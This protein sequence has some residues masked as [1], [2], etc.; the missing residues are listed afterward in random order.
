MSFS[1]GEFLQIETIDGKTISITKYHLIARRNRSSTS[2]DE[3][4]EFIFAK[5]LRINDSVRIIDQNH[6][7][8]SRIRSIE[9]VYKRGWIAPLTFEG[10]LFVND[11]F[12]SCFALI[13][14]QT[15]GQRFFFPLRIYSSLISS[16]SIFYLSDRSIE[17]IFLN[18]YHLICYFPIEDFLYC[19]NQIE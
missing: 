19:S 6:F 10:H 18:L 15:M 14:H 13:R 16:Q 17:K 2:P 8:Y 12:V 7:K 9:I 4:Q 3:S 1:S 5:D 11:V